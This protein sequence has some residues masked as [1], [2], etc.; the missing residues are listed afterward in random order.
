MR[1]RENSSHSSYDFS[2]HYNSEEKLSAESKNKNSL[3]LTLFRITIFVLSVLSAILVYIHCL[4]QPQ[5][6]AWIAPSWV[7]ILVAASIFYV[8]TYFFK[9]ISKRYITTIFVSSICIILASVV[10]TE[11]IATFLLLLCCWLAT[12]FIDTALFLYWTYN[13]QRKSY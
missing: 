4:Q 13:K 12:A 1:G 7:S 10:L 11:G 9:N 8:F 6:I 3:H 2:Y 5:N